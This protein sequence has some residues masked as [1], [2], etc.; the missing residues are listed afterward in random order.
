MKNTKKVAYGGIISALSLVILL[1]ASYIEVMDVSAVVVV[2]LGIVF[3]QIEFGTTASVT[4]FV[5]VSLLSVI[6]LP[7]KL[8]AFMYICFGGWYPIVK[9]FLERVKMPLSIVLKLAV[10]NVALVLYALSTLF[11][12][13]IEMPN[14]TLNIVL[15]AMAN[16][17]F[18][19]YDYALSRLITVYIFKIRNRFGKL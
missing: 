7:S 3:M 5:A 17:V 8:P 19:V 18:L 10:F 14:D 2:S 11:V 6:F 9:R 12:L 1:I 13:M 4:T 16:V 15:I